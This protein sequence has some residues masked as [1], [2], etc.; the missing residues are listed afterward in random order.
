[1]SLTAPKRFSIEEIM[2]FGMRQTVKFDTT[3][4]GMF[5]EIGPSMTKVVNERL[6]EPPTHSTVLSLCSEP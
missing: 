1:M 4:Y 2:P 5:F 6:K 3:K